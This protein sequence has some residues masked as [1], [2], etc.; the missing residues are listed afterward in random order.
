MAR[1]SLLADAHHVWVTPLC[2]R[3]KAKIVCGMD[4]ASR[5]GRAPHSHTPSKEPTPVAIRAKKPLTRGLAAAP[6][7]PYLCHM[8][9]HLDEMGPVEDFDWP[10]AEALRQIVETGD[11]NGS[12]IIGIET[13]EQKG[14]ISIEMQQRVENECVRNTIE[15]MSVS[16]VMMMICLPPLG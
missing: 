9:I 8:R 2:R 1:N 11:G 14:D 5:A 15:S 4:K 7:H 10:S 13:S 3:V 6:S 12:S 16:T